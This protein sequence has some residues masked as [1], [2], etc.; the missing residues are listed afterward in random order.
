[1][2]PQDPIRQHDDEVGPCVPMPAGHRTYCKIPARDADIRVILLDR[3][4]GGDGAF[5][6]HVFLW[7]YERT[8]RLGVTDYCAANPTNGAPPMRSSCRRTAGWKQHR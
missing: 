5:E 7:G 3:R 8:M 6:S 4:D 2:E 1:M